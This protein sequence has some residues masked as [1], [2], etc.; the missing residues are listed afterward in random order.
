MTK[1]AGGKFGVGRFS[2]KQ[3][4]REARQADNIERS[5]K[6]A[7]KFGG[8]KFG[9]GKFARKNITREKI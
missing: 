6:L 1:F 3:V 4:V 5:E 9:V 8:G 2:R 7:T